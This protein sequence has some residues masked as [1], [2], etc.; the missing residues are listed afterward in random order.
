MAQNFHHPALRILSPGAVIRKLHHNLMSRNR[1]LC[2]LQRNKNV[3]RNSLI[4]RNHK[5]KAFALLKGAHHLRDPV[6]QYLLN[7]TLLTPSL[8]MTL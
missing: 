8:G 2:M 5:A 7:H 1:P 3:L 6:G 4:V